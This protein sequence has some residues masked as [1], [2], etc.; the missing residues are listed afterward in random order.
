MKVDLF[1]LESWIYAFILCFIRVTKSITIEDIKNF[2]QSN[3]ICA[4]HPEYERGLDWKQ[5]QV[6]WAKSIGN[7]VGFALA[8]QILQAKFG[9]KY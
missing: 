3:S 9:K 6:H 7:A 1:C 2:R 5:L 4:G 8:E